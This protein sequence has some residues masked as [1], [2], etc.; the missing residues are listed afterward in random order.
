M[1]QRWFLLVLLATFLAGPAMAFDECDRNFQDPRRLAEDARKMALLRAPVRFREMAEAIKL[2]VGGPESASMPFATEQQG[3]R[4]VVVPKPFARIAC[5]MSLSTFLTVGGAP[6]NRFDQAA[7]AAA[8]CLDTGNPMA[9]CLSAF[10]SNLAAGY[11]DDFAEYSLEDRNVPLGIARGAL[12]QVVQHEYA[13]HYLGHHAK[14]AAGQISRVDAEFE[15]DLFAITNGL[16]SG[17]APT[18]MFYFFDGL[19]QI[20]SFTQKL[21]SPDYESG[22]CRATN[23]R[24]VSRF[25]GIVPILLL[26]A[27]FGGKYLVARNSPADLRGAIADHFGGASPEL[28]PESCGRIAKAAL[29]ATFGELKRLSARMQSD[30]ELL[31]G[32]EKLDVGRATQLVRDL[33]AMTETFQY[34]GGVASKSIALMLRGW[35]LKGGALTPLVTQVDRLLENRKVIG[36]LQGEDY[37]RLLAS[38]GLATLQERTDLPAE[39]RL[40]RSYALFEAS[41]RYND[42]NSEVWMNLAM[43]TFKRGDCSSASRYA[44]QALATHNPADKEA[45]EATGF[46]ARTMKELSADSAACT[47]QAA[48]FHPYKGL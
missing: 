31:F 27:A 41:T 47:E 29:E 14:L 2:V 18:A 38:Q 24:N 48:Q 35:G 4:I 40:E 39:P 44:D 17:D 36:D 8:K 13:H 22:T 12:W 3:T 1:R 5:Q 28:A 19:T 37:A 32:K 25:I 9:S 20:E 30:A 43:I 21:S 45:H 15:A 33:V 23:V 11:R 42:R 6:P 10:G 7:H 46:F 34:M 16:Q 26:D